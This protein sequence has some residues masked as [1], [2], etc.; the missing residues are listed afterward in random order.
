MTSVFVDGEEREGFILYGLWG[1]AVPPVDPIQLG[2][3]P[4]DTCEVR[5]FVLFGEGWRICLFE[6]SFRELEEYWRAV[7]GVDGALRELVGS[8]AQVAWLGSEGLPFADPPDLFTAEWMEGGVLLALTADGQQLG[9]VG[10]AGFEPLANAEMG[11]LEV[12]ARALEA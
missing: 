10:R 4:G 11:R 8:G 12:I 3:A 7:E 5:R 1:S 9:R 2:S 6:F